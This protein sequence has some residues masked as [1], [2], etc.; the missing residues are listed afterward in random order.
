MNTRRRLERLER[1]PPEPQGDPRAGARFMMSMESDDCQ[2]VVEVYL[3][4][5][6]LAA[7]G[8]ELGTNGIGDLVLTADSTVVC[9]AGSWEAI[10]QLPRE[11]FSQVALV[12]GRITGQ[13]NG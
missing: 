6:A 10:L 8:E 13:G 12:N 11:V 3:A 9:R 4:L 1:A 7:L 2:Q 5:E